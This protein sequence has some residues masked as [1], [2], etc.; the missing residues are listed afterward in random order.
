MEISLYPKSEIQELINGARNGATV[1]VPSGIHY[2]YPD[3]NMDS[4]VGMTINYK[5]DI[6][7]TGE[8]DSEIR[9][10]VSNADIFYINESNNITIKNITIGYYQSKREINQA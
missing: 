9:L 2:V 1:I 8:I 4:T 7:I 5:S 6:T 3:F 10:K